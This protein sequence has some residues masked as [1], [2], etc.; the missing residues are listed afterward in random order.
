MGEV[1]SVDICPILPLEGATL[2]SGL[3]FTKPK[4]HEIIH[5][6]LNGRLFDVVLS[7]MA[8]NAS[9]IKDLDDERMFELITSVL[10]FGLP[11]SNVGA[12]L[13]VKLWDCNQRHKLE[14][15]LRRFYE[16]VKMCKP[17]ASRKDS[18]EIY[19]LARN[20]K[21]LKKTDS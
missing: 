13:L 8:P 10:D 12:T 17:E 7:D 21:G 14:T 11:R 1:F 16:N 6:A 20:F 2:F 19:I 15:G 18:A 3:D 9:G 5:S 4:T